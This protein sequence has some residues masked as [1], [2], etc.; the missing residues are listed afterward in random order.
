MD[1]TL[2]DKTIDIKGKKY[3]MVKD[4]V[5]WLSTNLD[6]EYS[7]TTDY[8]YYE[9]QRMWVVKAQ[10][11]IFR[12]GRTLDYT[13]LAQEV[14][15]DDTTKVNNASALENCET[16]AIGR[17]CAAFGLGIQESYASANE[18][19]KIPRV[20]K[21][22]TDKQIDWIRREARKINDQ[23]G[24]DDEVDE[25]VEAILTVKPGQVPIYKVKD[26]IDKLK[27]DDTPATDIV[28]EVTDQDLE[29]LEQGKLPY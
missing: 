24:D 25:W 2:K 3:A 28:V 7:I 1:K 18:M 22:A 14:E 27:E 5:E 8:I 20:T 17:A 19:N 10:L 26:A 21:F 16:S 12:D 4:R 11:T 9:D 23:L 13:G 6:G 29:N 15:S